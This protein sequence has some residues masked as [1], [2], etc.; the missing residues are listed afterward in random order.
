VGTRQ[1]AFSGLV[2]K[3]KVEVIY[4]RGSVL[5]VVN[6]GILQ[7]GITSAGKCRSPISSIAIGTNSESVSKGQSLMPL[8]EGTRDRI[9]DTFWL[10]GMFVEVLHREFALQTLSC[11]TRGGQPLKPGKDQ[12]MRSARMKARKEGCTYSARDVLRSRWTIE[13][14][15]SIWN[16]RRLRISEMKE[17]GCHLI[18]E[19]HVHTLSLCSV[20]EGIGTI[21]LA[22]DLA[23]FQIEFLIGNNIGIFSFDGLP[24]GPSLAVTV[25]VL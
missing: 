1:G 8:A 22:V 3:T 19:I 2:R 25:R 11:R 16:F 5:Y 9:R 17:E 15:R 23:G 10:A 7:T 12:L 6:N 4:D 21:G 14:P 18:R 20:P 13:D 24:A